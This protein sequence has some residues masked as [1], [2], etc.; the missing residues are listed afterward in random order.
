MQKKRVFMYH[1]GEVC[2]VTQVLYVPK[3]F[4]TVLS[5]NRV[6]HHTFP[7]KQKAPRQHRNFWKTKQN[8]TYQSREAIK[9]AKQKQKQPR[10]LYLGLAFCHLYN[11]KLSLY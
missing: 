2:G 6:T 11:K 1:F 8:E 9:K 5:T 3:V 4:S 7:V 10:L